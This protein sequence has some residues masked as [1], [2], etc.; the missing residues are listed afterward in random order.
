[1]STHYRCARVC[2]A[3]VQALHRA[4]AMTHESMHRERKFLL[5]MT[6][7]SMHAVGVRINNSDRGLFLNSIAKFSELMPYCLLPRER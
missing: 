1:M 6:H 4:I 5:A 3:T 7:E 2:C